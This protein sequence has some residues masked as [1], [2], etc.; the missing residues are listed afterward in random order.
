MSEKP[1]FTRHPDNPI[2]T[3][4]ALPGAALIMNSA[5][6]PFKKGYA[7]VF[8]VDNQEGIMELHAGFSADGLKWDID[9][10]RLPLTGK[11]PESIP[12]GRGYDPRITRIGNT[13]YVTWC[14]YPCGQ[15]PAIG[16]ASTKDFRR[17]R[18]MSTVMLPY[19]RN[20]VLFP[21][22]IGG[23]YALLHRPSDNGHTPFGDIYYATSPD[24][25]HWGE[26]RFV[27]G[28]TDGWQGTKVG[29]GP[30][31]IEIREGWLVLYHGV[32][33]TCNGFVYSMGGAILDRRNPWIVLY[34]TKRYMMAPETDY[35]RVGFVPNVVFPTATLLDSKTGR[36]DV[37]YGAADTTV[38][39]ASADLKEVVAF[40]KRHSY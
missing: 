5:V 36:M 37:Y 19:N 3:P 26:H 4:D 6:V 27:F 22:K 39:L 12:A 34:R 20:A 7:G 2:I 38:G 25:M 33:T 13:W 24:L 30:T 31:P 29:A 40:I 18:Q 15:G 21:R 17:F 28:R 14:Y 11:T 35:E 8:R 16:L 32:I 10:K 23:K 9:P 1:L